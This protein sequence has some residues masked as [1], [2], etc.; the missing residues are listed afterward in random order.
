MDITKLGRF[1]SSKLILG[2]GVNGEAEL[3]KRKKSGTKK[4]ARALY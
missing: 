4:N 2:A 1:M 3:Q